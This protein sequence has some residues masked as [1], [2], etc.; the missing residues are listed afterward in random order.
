ME[1]P[2]NIIIYIDETSIDENLVPLYGYSKKGMKFIITS[3][4]K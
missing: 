3:K 4:P 2:A 1:N